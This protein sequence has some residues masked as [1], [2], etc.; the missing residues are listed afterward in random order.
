MLEQ[1]RCIRTMTDLIS[2][3]TKVWDSFFKNLKEIMGKLEE[4]FVG[5]KPKFMH[6]LDEGICY[7]KATWF[8]NQAMPLFIRHICNESISKNIDMTHII[9]PSIIRSYS[10]FE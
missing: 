5:D 9:S 8:D 7:W 3:Y 1:D 2:I 10:K 4:E 6:L